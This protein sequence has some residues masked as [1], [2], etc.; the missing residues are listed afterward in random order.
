M[1]T[2][3]ACNS[4]ERVAL[5]ALL[6]VAVS[7]RGHRE[8]IVVTELPAAPGLKENAQ[9]IFPGSRAGRR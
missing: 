8:R 4:S 1:T 6:A 5:A 2:F 3:R 7:C 9:V